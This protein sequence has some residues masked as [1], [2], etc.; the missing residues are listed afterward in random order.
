MTVNL[1]RINFF[2]KIKTKSYCNEDT[3]FRDKEIHILGSSYTS[4]AVM[5]IDFVLWKDENYYEQSVLKEF[6]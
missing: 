2:A 1:L 4:L 6:K 3:E 5:L